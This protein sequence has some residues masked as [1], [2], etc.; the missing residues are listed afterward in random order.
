MR[1]IALTVLVTASLALASAAPAAAPEKFPSRPIDFVVT[2]GAGGGADAMAR[3]SAVILALAVLLVLG[4]TVRRW[5]GGA[6]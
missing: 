6:A 2:W 1:R 4:P 5:A 3:Q